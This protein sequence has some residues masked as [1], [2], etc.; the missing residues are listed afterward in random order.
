MMR[1][2]DPDAT[3]RYLVNQQ[4]GDF[5]IEVPASWRPT[6]SAVNPGKGAFSGAELHCMRLWEGEKLRAVY[7][8]VR[9][10]RDLSIPMARKV[11]SETR[12][13]SWTQDSS[14]NFKGTDERQIE[15]S[16]WTPDDIEDPF[17]S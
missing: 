12:A 5:V 10:F 4:G 8:D 11:Q 3:I 13:A 15:K 9:G 17:G 1:Q 16:T 6:F 7:C 14:G 2:K